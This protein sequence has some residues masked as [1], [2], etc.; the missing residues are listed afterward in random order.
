MRKTVFLVALLAL[1]CGIALG[2]ETP[3]AEVFGGYQYER[4]NVAGTGANFNGWNASIAGNF[5][6][7][8]G[9]A[10]DFSGAYHS[11]SG[12][13]LKAYTYAFGPVV[14][15]NHEGMVNPF[16]HALFGG[17]HATLSVSGVGSAGTSGFTMLMGGGVDAK[18]APRIA[19]RVIQAD[20]VYYHFGDFGSEASLSKN[21]R[22]ST[23]L[24]FRF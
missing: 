15:L 6:K 23:G 18:V 7:T 12:G 22:I 8:F 11:E 3:K 5:N 4:I 20:W 16:V 24:V 10:A 1:F 17:A 2:E 13:S 21:M 9:V 19:V 14:S